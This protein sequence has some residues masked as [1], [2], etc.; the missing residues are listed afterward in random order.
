MNIEAYPG[1]EVTLG[2]IIYDDIIT[3]K[4]DQVNI[5][6]KIDQKFETTTLS[7]LSEVLIEANNIHLTADAEIY[8]GFVML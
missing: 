6:G 4:G 3:I 2:S 8:A 7:L 5:G 1:S